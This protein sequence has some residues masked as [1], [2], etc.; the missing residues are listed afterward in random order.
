MC[1]I[2]AVVRRP[3]TRPIPD[4]NSL[5]ESITDLASL[6]RDGADITTGLREAADRLSAA[7]TALQGVPGLH[8]WEGERGLEEWE[9]SAR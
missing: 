9:T 5:I 4:I 8:G 6:V 2:I 7:D 1:G 3:S